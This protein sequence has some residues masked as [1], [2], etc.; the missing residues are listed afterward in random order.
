MRLCRKIK[1]PLMAVAMVALAMSKH[2]AFGE[3]ARS[4][5]KETKGPSKSKSPKEAKSRKII[6]TI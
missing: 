4:L 1:F 5:L 6:R 3:E 2:V